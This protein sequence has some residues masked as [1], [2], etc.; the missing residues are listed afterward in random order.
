MK[1]RMNQE[2]SRFIPSKASSNRAIKCIER[3]QR[4]RKF[5]CRNFDSSSSSSV[6]GDSDDGDDGDDSDDGDDGDDGRAR[7]RGRS[8]VLP[9]T[10]RGLMLP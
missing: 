6:G 5:R 8:N 2:K 3:E 4:E 7:S 9:P 10:L 1:I